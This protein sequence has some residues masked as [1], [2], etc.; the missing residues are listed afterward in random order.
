[1]P[2]AIAGQLAP[3]DRAEARIGGEALHLCRAVGMPGR[4]KEGESGKADAQAL[5][6]LEHDRLLSAV[7][8]AC[9]PHEIAFGDPEQAL[10]YGLTARLRRREVRLEIAGDHHPLGQGAEGNDAAGIFLRL[11]GE[12]RDIA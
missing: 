2:L 11:H 6:S 3:P 12:D 1:V 9:D 5:E 4:E 7:R 10:P 8:A